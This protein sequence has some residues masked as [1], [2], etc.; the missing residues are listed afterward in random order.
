[1]EKYIIDYLVLGSV[2]DGN[3]LSIIDNGQYLSELKKTTETIAFIRQ[4]IISDF[5]MSRGEQKKQITNIS[6][7]FTCWNNLDA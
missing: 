3:T 1:M 7:N 5:I 6:I 4:R 2:D